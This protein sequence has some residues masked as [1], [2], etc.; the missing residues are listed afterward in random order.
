M[1][2]FRSPEEHAANPPETWV[3]RK[4]ADRVWRL[5]TKDGV[6]LSASFARKKDAEDA[7]T[8]GFEAR[9]YAD[10]TRWYAGEQVNGWKTYQQCL[11]ERAATIARRAARQKEAA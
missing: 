5:T 3:V 6:D 10:E 7:K 9:L 8:T 2:M 4:S 1:V 11:D